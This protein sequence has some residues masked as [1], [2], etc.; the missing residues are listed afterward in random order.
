MESV[1]QRIRLPAATLLRLAASFVLALLLWG[2]VTDRQDPPTPRVFEDLPLQEPQLDAPLQVVDDLAGR[3]VRVVVEGP[4]SVVE[5]LDESELEPRLDL[6]NIDGRGT[7]TVPVEVTLPPAARAERTT[8]R[9]LTIIV[10][11]TANQAFHLDQ[12]VISEEDD[13]LRIGEISSDVTQVTVSGPA[14][15]VADVARV[16]L[17]IEVGER[18]SDFT[19][20]FV[21]EARNRDGEPITEVQIQPERVAVTV[22]VEARGRSVPVLIQTVGVPAEGYEEFGRVANP[23]TV[24]LDGPDAAVNDLVSVSTAPITIEGATEPVRR[25]IGVADLPPGV[26]V[27]AP[28]GGEVDV[29]V[30]IRPRGTTQTLADQPVL[31][32]DLAPGLVATSEPATIDVE[33]FAAEGTLSGLQAGDIAT[34]VLAAGLGPGQHRLEVG[35]RV[36]AGVQWLRTEPETVLVT[37]APGEAPGAT[38]A[39]G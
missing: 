6:S 3:T 14:Q 24:V 22:P 31:V 34:R 23:D 35:V 15:F 19:D 5:D 17:P 21:P 26:D 9:Q 30:Q 16:V 20:T 1:L 10:D 29:V 2:W 37:I 12:E 36:P 8:P 33:I 32:T 11:E 4:R 7:Y 18:T 13:S 28:P 25:S 27:V 39:A 38:P